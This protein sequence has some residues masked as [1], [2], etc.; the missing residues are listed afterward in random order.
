MSARVTCLY[1][2][3]LSMLMRFWVAHFAVQSP[4]HRCLSPCLTRAG[5]P[6]LILEATEVDGASSPH[7]S[8]HGLETS[9]V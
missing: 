2:G 1:L 7:K 3:V 5:P 9:L 8:E 4:T 6:V